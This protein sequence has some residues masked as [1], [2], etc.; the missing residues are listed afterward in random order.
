MLFALGLD[1]RIVGVTSD[2][3]YPP[4]ART[5][6]R[7]GKFA[8][9]SREQLV[10]L[11]PD[12]I[13]APEELKTRLGDLRSLTVPVVGVSAPDLDAMLRA[14]RRL[15]ALT[16]Q[17]R[18][19]ARVVTE[20][21]AR[22]RRTEAAAARQPRR[23]VF[24]YLWPDPLITAGSNSFIGDLIRRAGG[25]DVAGKLS[26]A[27]GTGS[28]SLEQLVVRQPEVLVVPRSQETALQVA[29]TQSPW[30]SLPAAQRHWV[31]VVD[32]DWLARPGPRAVLALE[33][34]QRAFAHQ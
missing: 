23:R 24:C 22:A 7:V 1:K 8:F 28:F 14:L 32:D 3:N 2:C 31:V 12:L 21:Q 15:G 30:N 11:R 9:V 27:G 16:G 29:L 4:A 25:E 34:M 33:Q 26:G 18:Q 20:L 6:A 10:S 13:V 5:R 19:A 17:D